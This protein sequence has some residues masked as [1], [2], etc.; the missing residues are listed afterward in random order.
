MTK[1]QLQE[2][3]NKLESKIEKTEK[4]QFKYYDKLSAT[5]RRLALAGIGRTWQERKSLNLNCDDEN[6]L[7]MYYTKKRE[8]EDSTNTLNKYKNQLKALD[9]LIEIPVLRDFLNKWEE[10]TVEYLINAT[11]AYRERINEISNKYYE[12][13]IAINREASVQAEKERKELYKLFG[14]EVV[15]LAEY[16]REKDNQIKKEVKEEAQRKY[17]ALVRKISDVVGEIKDCDRLSIADDGK[18]NGIIEGSKGK[19]KITTIVAGG[20]NEDIIVNVKHG[21]CAHYRVLVREL[22]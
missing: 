17:K 22:D 9:D 8:L 21:Q 14:R 20:Y 1:E 16:R 3:I 12:G 15:R 18:I 5:A 6:N 2:R 11:D 19:V 7:D 4:N 13:G 10:D